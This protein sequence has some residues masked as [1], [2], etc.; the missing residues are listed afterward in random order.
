MG[1]QQPVIMCR[2]TF[3]RRQTIPPCTNNDSFNELWAEDSGVDLWAVVEGRA[4]P[5][6]PQKENQ[7]TST[8]SSHSRYPR[9]KKRSSS[10]TK[11]PS[12]APPKPAMSKNRTVSA[13]TA[14][15]SHPRLEH[16]AAPTKT[17]TLRQQE[18]SSHSS[19]SNRNAMQ[20]KQR[21]EWKELKQRAHQSRGKSSSPK[22]TH[23]INQSSSAGSNHDGRNLANQPLRKTYYAGQFLDA[24][25]L[26]TFVND[27][28]VQ[29]R[30]SNESS[31]SDHGKR[32]RIK[33]NSSGQRRK[34]NSELSNSEHCH[35]SRFRSRAYQ[36][37]RCRSHSP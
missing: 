32:N 19:N 1:K 37:G 9:A 2:N 7:E 23:K 29:R 34:P 22:T 5:K 25:E 28:S 11:T 13:P 17:L 14:P 30:K 18:S 4:R 6:P 21:R 33:N 3:N 36:N 12:A 31:S 8:S 15:P 27:F 10:M 24:D 35:R 26:V 16:S 20:T